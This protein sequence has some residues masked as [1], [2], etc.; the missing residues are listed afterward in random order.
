MHSDERGEMAEDI[1]TGKLARLGL[2][3]DACRAGAADLLQRVRS[4]GIETV[5]VL[6]A[7]QHGILRGKTIVADA[8]DSLFSAGLNVPSTLLLKDTSHRTAF[9]VW[10]EADDGPA[11]LMQGA[12]DVLLVP[13][14]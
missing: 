1:S 12:S 2:L 10:S 3:S 13:R 11:S 6:F 14:P 9:P 7:D 8:F 5:R 4:E